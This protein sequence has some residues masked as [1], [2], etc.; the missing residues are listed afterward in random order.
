MES[1]LKILNTGANGSGF[2]SIITFYNNKKCLIN[3]GDSTLRFCEEIKEKLINVIAIIITSF[4]PHNYSGL[5]SILLTLSDLGVGNITIFG[6]PGLEAILYLMSPFTNRKYPEINIKEIKNDIENIKLD[7]IITISIQPIWAN[8]NN[9][10]NNNNSSPI[11]IS[12]I[13][14]STY[15]ENN[16]IKKSSLLITPIE[17]N[18]NIYPNIKDILKWGNQNYCKVTLFIPLTIDINK[19][20]INNN[21]LNELCKI[22]STIGICING[23]LKPNI[24]E[25]KQ[26]QKSI[27][28]ANQVCK[29]LFPQFINKNNNNN[30]KINDDDDYDIY[31]TN[32]GDIIEAIPYML[33]KIPYIICTL[34][35]DLEIEKNEE[36]E[37]KIKKRKLNDEIV[38]IE[39]NQPKDLT[40]SN[41]LKNTMK[42]CDEIEYTNNAIISDIPSPK[43]YD[44]NVM[45]LGTG[46]AKSSKYRNNSCICINSTIFS[47]SNNRVTILLDVGESVCAQIL[48]S[49]NG[50]LIRYYN[51]LLSISCIWISHHHADHICGLPFLLEQIFRAYK[52]LKFLLNDKNNID[53]NDEINETVNNHKKQRKILIICS[54]IVL[55][56]YEYCVCIAGLENLVHFMPINQTLYVGCTKN[57]IDATD[58]FIQRLIS[59]PVQ[60]C[61]DSYAV[62]L[63]IM[64]GYKIVYSGDCRPSSSI[65]S[66]GMNCDLLI[67]EATF[68]DTMSCDAL[69]KRHSTTSEA[70]GM[71]IKMKCKNII[72][73]H[74]SQRY[75][76]TAQVEISSNNNDH[77]DETNNNNIKLLNY[78]IAYDFMHFSFP[79]QINVLHSITTKISK[80]Y[81]K[82]YGKKKSNL[83]SF[84]G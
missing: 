58:G 60:H 1:Y 49:V 68:D 19:K 4:A 14:T 46:A 54:D 44:F 62:V 48:Y 71:G 70:I 20:F 40:F 33:V 38:I 25:F 21:N 34:H 52:E 73:T 17:Y 51:F 39:I 77:N 41:D 8:N 26:P 72:L 35:D 61:H 7:N 13:I 74:F 50:D 2:S 3:C 9:N 53:I 27:F 16:I 78:A 24:C 36:E 75:L 69:K 81:E 64:N 65:I 66:A 67:H 55:K 30:N 76:S 83:Q 84:N 12:S 47:N 45:F 43:P 10:N 56:Y 23:T 37:D 80:Y 31:K 11:A 6:P 29:Y 32:F 18:F 28:I 5:P 59:I 63:E 79:S 15:I 57:I 22:Y 82:Y 42:I